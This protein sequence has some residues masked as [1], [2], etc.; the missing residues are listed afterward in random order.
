[1]KCKHKWICDEVIS[2]LSFNI[3][4]PIKM[5]LHCE[6]CAEVIIKKIIGDNKHE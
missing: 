4:K 5:I 1:M 6:K 3:R 2:S